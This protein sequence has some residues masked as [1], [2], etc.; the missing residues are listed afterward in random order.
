M[1]SIWTVARRELKALFDQP[2]G[3]ILLII[4]LGI[5]NFLFFRQ[6]FLFNV[7]SLRPMLELLPWLFLFFVPAVTMRSLAE[8]RRNGTIEVVLCNP[9]TELEF[10]LGKY[11]G[12]VLFVWFAVALTLAVPAGLALGADLHLGVVFAQYVGTALLAAGLVAVGVWS[13]SLTKNQITAFIIGVLVMFLL[14]LVGL[15]PLLLG[16]PPGLSAAAARLGVL[17]HFRDIARGVIDLRDAVYFVTLAAV[18][19]A[20]AYFSLMAGKLSARGAA[21]QRLRLGVAIIVVGL[22]VVNLFGRSIG[23]R[24]DLTPGNAYTLSKATKDLLGNL[25]DLVTIKLFASKELPTEVALLR[26][27]IDDVLRDYRAAGGSRVRLVVQ[28]PSE[29]SDV[30][31]EARSLGIP[32][33]QFNVVGQSQFTVRD[34]YLGLAVEHLDQTEVIPFIQQTDDLEYRLTSFIHGM[35]DTTK[36]SVGYFVAPAEQQAPG[37]SFQSLHDQLG[38]TYNVRSFTL[39][40]DSSIPDTAAV[41]VLIG[42]PDSLTAAQ[43]DVLRNYFQRGGSALI[44]GSGMQLGEQQFATA[45]PVAWNDVL[46]PYGVSIKSDMVYDLLS[47]ESVAFNT[48]FGRLFRPYPL[49]VRAISTQASSVNQGVETLFTPWPS[50]VDTSGA[51]SGTVIPLFTSS[52]GAGAE[53]NFVMLDPSRNFPQDSLRPRLIAALINPMAVDKPSGPT[54]RLAVV[55]SSMFLVDRFFQN[56]PD[57]LAFALNAVDWLAQDE[58]LISIRAKNRNPPPLVFSSEAKSRFVKYANVVGVPLVLAIAA[59]L[60]MLSRRQ[61]TRQQYARLVPSAA[62]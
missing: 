5:N 30:E 11:V 15:D 62:L 34:G 19:V 28:D 36:Q 50:S 33:V 49:W 9:V 2:T 25:D 37:F 39:E 1:T 43:K 47:S 32:P 58:S 8:E 7:A 4:F 56:N 14:I 17:A 59:V 51:Q 16:L 23:G 40:S 6:A 44:A 31:S 55:G 10:L 22:V 29:D 21:R 61:R 26:R 13:S 46:K 24:L 57:N 35:V 60:H 27:D 18:F 38:K 41:L 12:Q 45:R 42:S 20:L 54:G 53:E 48:Q 52:K 3:Y